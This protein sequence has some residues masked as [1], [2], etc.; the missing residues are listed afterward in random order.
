MEPPEKP[1]HRLSANCA[2]AAAWSPRVGE[3][4]DPE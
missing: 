1:F 2:E 4:E 3:V